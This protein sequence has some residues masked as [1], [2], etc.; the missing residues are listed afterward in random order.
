MSEEYIRTEIQAADEALISA[1]TKRF[2]AL[3]A[4]QEIRGK[5]DSEISADLALDAASVR[6]IVAATPDDVPRDSI[7][8]VLR[9]VI[10]ECVVFQGVKTVCFTA[11]DHE[12]M[13]SA[14]RGMFGYSVNLVPAA[15]WREALEMAS[16]KTG[17]IAC[18]PWPETPG[19][20]QW[21][22]ALIE[23]RFDALRILA[24]WPNLPGE[25]RTI[26]DTAVVAKQALTPSGSDDTFAIGHDDLH[27]AN[28]ILREASLEGEPVARVRTLA[29]IRLQG[30]VHEDDSRLAEARKGGLEGL[31][32]VGALPRLSPE[33][34]ASATSA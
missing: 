5:E 3:R 11:A 15:D 34:G 19:S 25:R 13:V 7:A 14:A 32:V 9:T 6:R 20:G 33:G 10:G 17:V 4:L 23:D 16:E 28:R 29:L 2:R 12:R 31:R 24:G 30:F 27:E 8:R 22:P 26:L 18:L 1:F 21:W